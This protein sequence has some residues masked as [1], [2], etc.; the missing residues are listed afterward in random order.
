MKR[1][2]TSGLMVL[3][4][5]SAAPPAATLREISRA[6]LKQA[7][8][9]ARGGPQAAAHAPLQADGAWWDD[10]TGGMI[11]GILGT[12]VGCLGGLI[13]GLGGTGKARRLVLGLMKAA[14]LA[15]VLLAAVGVTALVYSQPYAV[16]YPLLL[17]GVLCCAIMG[18]LLP[19]LRRRYEQAEL[20][21]M[22]AFDAA[23]GPAGP[24]S[25]P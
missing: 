14:I 5:A 25:A 10:R 1:L 17:T 6:E 22:A 9:L 11:G 7:G 2:I 12:V 24:D 18:S 4:A 8:P 23:P 16:W 13:G 21:K 19:V 3:A 15:G 20:R